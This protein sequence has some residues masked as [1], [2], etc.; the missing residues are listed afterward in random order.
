MCF[1]VEKGLSPK[2]VR[3]RYAIS[4]NVGVI[5]NA[6]SCAYGERG[7]A[8]C[9]RTHLHYIFSCFWQ[10]FGLIVSCFICRNLTLLYSKKMCSTTRSMTIVMK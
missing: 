1:L 5:E 3:N 9:V 4:G 10:H 8:S 6:H 2:Y 7:R